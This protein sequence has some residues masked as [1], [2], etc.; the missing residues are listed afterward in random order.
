MAAKPC[1]T[2]QS[3]YYS[4]GPRQPYQTLL[5][6]MATSSL[7]ALRSSI[8]ITR[9]R[10]QV[11]RIWALLPP[12]CPTRPRRRRRSLRSAG[13]PPLTPPPIV[14]GAYQQPHQR[15]NTLHQFT[16]RIN[17]NGASALNNS[18]AASA[19]RRPWFLSRSSRRAGR[20]A[21]S[22]RVMHSIAAENN[23]LAKDDGATV[24]R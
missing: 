7:A 2:S 17:D 3:Q 12:S 9:S 1:Q 16:G 5:A 15:R 14:R 11:I 19:C 13:R 21:L 22:A 10:F 23:S 8:I 24:S 18:S 20:A 6:Y 4:S